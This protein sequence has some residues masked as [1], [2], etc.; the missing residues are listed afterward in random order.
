MPSRPIWALREPIRTRTT[1][2]IHDELA[3]LNDK[4]V[5]LAA[6][7]GRNLEALLG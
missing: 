6:R 4:A 5:E 1:R 3:E 7:I 2:E